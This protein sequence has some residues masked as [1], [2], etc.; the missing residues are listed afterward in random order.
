[1]KGLG[2]WLPAAEVEVR[3][4]EVDGQEMVAIK[5]KDKG[6]FVVAV[7]LTPNQALALAGPLGDWCI[8]YASEYLAR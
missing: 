5:V 3:S 7:Y 8:D 4:I 1:V 6:D 2:D